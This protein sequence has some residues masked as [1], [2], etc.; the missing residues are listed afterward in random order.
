MGQ[1]NA[2]RVSL[3]N[4][5]IKDN[6][7]KADDL[8]AGMEE[9]DFRR[10][11]KE[12]TGILDRTQS[13]ISAVEA[14][15]TFTITPVGD[16][17]KYFIR[18]EEFIVDSAQSIVWDDIEGLWFFHF[19]ATGTLIATQVP[20]DFEFPIAFLALIYWNATD[21]ECVLFAEERH[22]LVMD[23]ATHKR[24]HEVQGTEIGKDQFKNYN[25]E[26]R[27]DGSQNSHAEFAI[28]DGSLYDE[29]I[30]MDIV[31]TPT[32][33]NQFEQTLSPIAKI[34]IYYK[35]ASELDPQWRKIQAQNAPLALDTGN[36]PF[37]NELIGGNWQLTNC[38]ENEYI[39]QTICVTNDVREPVIALLSPLSAPS[40]SGLLDRNTF[41]D[42][43]LNL[44]FT[45]I[46]PVSFLFYQ[47]SAAYG[48]DYKAR[49]IESKEISDVNE[50]K[51]RYVI[52][53]FYNGNANTG[54]VLE[55]VDGIDSEEQPILIPDDSFVV[56]V[57]VQ[58][59]ANIT[60]NRRIGFF[61]TNDLVNPIFE[62]TMTPGGSQNYRFD[63]SEFLQEGT[64][65]S[66]RV[67]QGSISKPTVRF[68]IETINI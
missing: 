44:P 15:R 39:V 48:N 14:T 32:P 67:T 24:L 17:F 23:W 42:E 62:V 16:S 41:R 11:T 49:L 38:P 18:G 33:T 13:T 25:L 12:P 5:N 31:D 4:R 59:S 40:I 46:A 61:D 60:N 26:I 54:R 45:E 64:R 2:R 9:I 22:G 6:D 52:T 19:D 63:V 21:K 56:T 8:Q 51:D 7:Y 1:T 68:W 37:Y 47:C 36:T 27:Q 66:V 57:T 53:S 34:P 28:T 58:A 43:F 35:V 65:L 3:D 30:K 55:Y 50:V 20:W 10:E 29:D